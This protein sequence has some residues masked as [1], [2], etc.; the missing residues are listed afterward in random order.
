MHSSWQYLRASDKYT[1]FNV[2]QRPVTLRS[3]RIPSVWQSTH[4]ELYHMI[5]AVPKK[6]N[7]SN[8]YI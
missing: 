5:P 8:I 2:I 7:T 4:N 6:V 1:E 3:I